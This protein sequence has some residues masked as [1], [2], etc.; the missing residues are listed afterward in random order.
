MDQISS[1]LHRSWSLCS[2]FSFSL[3]RRSLRLERRASQHCS[4]PTD[5]SCA[6]LPCAPFPFLPFPFPF[7]LPVSRHNLFS[8][9]V[10]VRGSDHS[11]RSTI[12][13][14]SHLSLINRFSSTHASTR[15]HSGYS[16]LFH[17]LFYSEVSEWRCRS[18]SFVFFAFERPLINE[19]IFRCFANIS[20]HARILRFF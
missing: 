13:A 17:A 20:R 10:W 3:V 11:H 12:F 14:R 8:T 6:A 18:R 4:A 9:E 7:F 16:L 1:L 2:F 5:D 19:P 15:I